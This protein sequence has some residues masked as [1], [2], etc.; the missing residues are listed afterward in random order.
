MIALKNFAYGGRTFR[1]GQTVEGVPE[2]MLNDMAQRGLIGKG[3]AVEPETETD[4]VEEA[5]EPKTVKK[6]KK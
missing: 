1:D 6:K 3:A 4:T 2:A 5:E